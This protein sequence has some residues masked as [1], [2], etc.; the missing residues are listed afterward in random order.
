[1]D[2]LDEILQRVEAKELR[3]DDHETIR[4]VIE[5]Y[6]GLLYYRQ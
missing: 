3:A 1:M 6:V 4:T 5:S 2:K